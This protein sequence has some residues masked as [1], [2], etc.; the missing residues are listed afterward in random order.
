MNDEKV[1]MYLVRIKTCVHWRGPV[2]DLNNL[3]TWEACADGRQPTMR[4]WNETAPCRGAGGFC[5]G[6]RAA[7]IV[8]TRPCP[9]TG[10]LGPGLG[11]L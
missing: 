4:P 6:Y 1:K 7:P 5:E 8:M 9:F 2:P 3:D 11:C 10:R